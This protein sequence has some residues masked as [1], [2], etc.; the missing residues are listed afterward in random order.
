MV[1]RRRGNRRA[2]GGVAELEGAVTWWQWVAIAWAA[3]IGVAVP[4]VRAVRET[5]TLRRLQRQRL[6]DLAAEGRAMSRELHERIKPMR[7]P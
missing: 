4:I 6:R 7:M 3:A 1:V 2:H 5:R